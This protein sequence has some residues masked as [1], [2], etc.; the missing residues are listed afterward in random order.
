MKAFYYFMF[1]LVLVGLVVTP[2]LRARHLT[3]SQFLGDEL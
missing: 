2:G 1:I 3:L